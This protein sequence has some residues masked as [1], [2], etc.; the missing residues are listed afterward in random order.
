MA[1]R[2]LPGLGTVRAA[3]LPVLLTYFAYGASTITQIA[4]LYLQKETL[5]LTPA[6]VAHV[7]FWANLP[8][9]MKMVVGAASDAFP[10][11]GNRRRPYLIAGALLS[12]AGYAAL[13]SVVTTKGTYLAA[14]VAIA[15]GF[16]VQDVIADALSVEVA[17]DDEEMAQVQTLGRMSLLAGTVAVGYLSGILAGALGPRPVFAMATALPALVL[18]SA[19]F[20]RTTRPDLPRAQPTIGRTSTVMGVGL[21]YGLLGVALEV[22]EIPL[23]QEIVLVVSGVLILL[24]LRTVGITRAVAIA[25]GTI[26]LF[27]AAP[28]VGQGYSY[29]AI[30]RLGFDQ[31]FLGILAQVGAVLGLLSLIFLRQRIVHARVSTTFTWIIIAGAVLLLPNIGLFYGLHE[32]LGV[33][34]RAIAVID[35]TITAPLVQLAMVPMLILIARTAP[36]GNEATMFAIM[37]SLMNLALSSRDLFTRYLNEFYTVTQQDYANLGRLMLTVCVLNLIPLI[38]IPFLR[39]AEAE[40]PHKDGSPSEERVKP[41][42]ATDGHG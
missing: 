14:T 15:I 33:S 3:W 12:I 16:M 11:A 24:L 32:W 42:M 39:R 30:D 23:A 9:S 27:R 18:V 6:E 35:T 20:V 26:F 5:A 34:A 40:L 25:A 28:D 22:L 41:P 31:Q 7:A 37:A 10:V 19:F 36:P 8:W 4:L 38:A 29:W 17:A 2:S 13:A 1:Q 21:G